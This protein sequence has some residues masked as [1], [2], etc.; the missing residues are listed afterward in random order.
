MKTNL[1]VIPHHLIV[2]SFCLLTSV[3]MLP[4]HAQTQKPWQ[5]VKQLGSA[6]W[7]VAGGVA[8]DAKNNLYVAGSF[9][10][11]L[12]A[13]GK[14]I[15]TKGGS[16]LFLAS[17]DT[18][19]NIGN[20]WGF[21]G[22]GR[23]VATCI[24]IAPDN[25]TIIG[26]SVSDTVSFGKLKSTGIGERLFLAAIDNKGN[27]SWITSI[28]HEENASMYLLATDS[29]G[30]IYAAGSFSGKLECGGK[31]VV[32]KGKNDIFILRLTALGS[33]DQLISFGSEAAESLGALAV[34]RVG[35]ITCSGT[36]TR[37]FTIDTAKITP[38]KVKTSQFLLHFN[39]D[40]ILQ[41]SRVIGAEDYAQIS[42]IS[43]DHNNNLY[44][45]GNFNMNITLPDTT[46]K[47][48]GYTDAF[49][50]K[51]TPG[52]TRLWEKSIGSDYYDYIN[53]INIDNLNGIV[54]TGS[55]G[56]TIQLDSLKIQPPVK[57]DAAF[58]AQFDSLGKTV[59]GDYI[60]G[61]GRNF[62]SGALLD[63]EGNLY[64]CGSFQNTF[65]RNDDEIKSYGDQD[66][67]L[68]KY[69]NCPDQRL[70][71][72]GSLILCPG[73]TT[74]IG[75][76][77]PYKTI[78]WNDTLIGNTWLKVNKPGGY[79]AAILTK[80]GCR[81]ADSV[82]ITQVLT[83]KFTLGVDTAIA[84]TDS[85]ELRAPLQF[86][87]YRWF[88]G[89]YAPTCIAASKDKKPSTVNFWIAVTDSLGCTWGDTIAVTFL[90]VSDI[91]N[92][93]HLKLVTYPNPLT[94]NLSWYLESDKPC[95]LL[96]E[97]ADN[98]GHVLYNEQLDYY[99]P[100]EVKHIPM[101]NVPSG[102]YMVRIK[103]TST[104]QV[105]SSAPVVKQ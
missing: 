11:T 66:I 103:S 27:A 28:V 32:S 65:K 55:I 49:I 75:V 7:D 76:K 20:L 95:R 77:N 90:P 23:D 33:V 38:A 17:F 62:G 68:A 82:T 101:N 98:Y 24:A 100:A 94:D 50:V 45:A 26:G 91:S 29:L 31:K 105:Y 10:Q 58:I 39:K 71:F 80:Y 81:Y 46:F 67:F 56:D 99:S 18:K 73:G 69:Y 83:P 47:S 19:G 14:K 21:G 52:G 16:D 34:N 15:T 84:V 70:S 60:G 2:I 88:D 79:K 6:T 57:G 74:E 61:T 4:L 85:M 35:E 63:K 9:G 64:L 8:I 93:Q 87:D 53:R 96:V 13:D 12:S 25:T 44:V 51:Y 48:N 37:E 42:A 40:I 43:Y 72:Q 102:T 54:V 41:W 89:S 3:L 22:K 104:G 30:N 86:R 78:V 59:W 97:V 5:W 36:F 92:L 1:H